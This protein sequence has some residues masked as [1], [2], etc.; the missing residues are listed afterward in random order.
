MGAKAEKASKVLTLEELDQAFL[1][2][3]VDQCEWATD[4]ARQCTAAI[5]TLTSRY[6]NQPEFETLQ[7]FYELYFGSGGAMDAKKNAINAEVDDLVAQLQAQQE[8]GEELI[9]PAED[10]TKKKDRLS[11]SAVQKKLETLITFDGGIRNQI[12]PALASMQSE[13]AVRQ[14]VEHISFGWRT[15]IEASQSQVSNNADWTTIARTI[16]AKMSSIL[17]STIYYEKVLGEIPPEGLSE[18]SVFLEF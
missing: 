8:R 1:N 4:E 6:I 11:L 15:L 9:L 13:D 2:I 17:E 14:R 16:A 5:F 10:E 18:Q 7:Q 3:L 12:L